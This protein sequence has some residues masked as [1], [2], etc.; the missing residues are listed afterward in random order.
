MEGLIVETQWERRV[1][2]ARRS[3]RADAGYSIGKPQSEGGVAIEWHFSGAV[4]KG[5]NG[6]KNRDAEHQ[7]GLETFAAI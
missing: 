7:F 4:G 6:M 5:G 3:A 1:D 2:F